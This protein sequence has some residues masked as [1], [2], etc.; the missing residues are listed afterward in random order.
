MDKV[1]KTVGSQ[2]D[3][4]IND[5]SGQVQVRVDN[6]HL[7][8]TVVKPIN[9]ITT[10]LVII[11]L[12]HSEP[13]HSVGLS[14]FHLLI[15]DGQLHCQVG[16]HFLHLLATTGLFIQQGK[17]GHQLRVE[18]MDGLLVLIPLLVLNILPLAEPRDHPL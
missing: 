13:S 4:I 3:G 6:S 11:Q 12:G 15:K 17:F 8:Q 7:L 9:I 16:V 14:L 18:S 5:N 10:T 2:W 1:V